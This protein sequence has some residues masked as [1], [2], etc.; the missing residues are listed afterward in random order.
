M[1]TPFDDNHQAC[2][3]T[4]AHT[5]TP[6]EGCSRKACSIA[7][8]FF[9]SFLSQ[10]L[11]EVR[12]TFSSNKTSEG[13]NSTLNHLNALIPGCWRS[14][15]LVWYF[16]CIVPFSW[17]WC[18]VQTFPAY[19]GRKYFPALEQWSLSGVRISLLAML[20][21]FRSTV[22]F[23]SWTLFKYNTTFTLEF[24]QEL[25]GEYIFTGSKFIYFFHA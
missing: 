21:H 14:L 12:Q 1:V 25:F 16:C 20:K 10:L 15:S 8:C 7:A 9:S 4:H 24:V 11:T 17:L 2:R 6:H 13:E 19:V 22:S 3:T 5:Q 23:S 18:Q